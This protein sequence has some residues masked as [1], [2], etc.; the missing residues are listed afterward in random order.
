MHAQTSVP[1][2]QIPFV[3]VILTHGF[4]LF[5][6]FAG[7]SAALTMAMWLPIFAGE[8]GFDSPLPLP[9]W[10]AHEMLFGFAAAG[11]AGFLLA[12]VP[13]WTNLPPL[14]GWRLGALFAVWLAGRIAAW[15]SGLLPPLVF[16]VVDVLFLPSLAAAV[17]PG[18][19]RRSAKRNGVFVLLIAALVAGNV[20]I[21]VQPIL[22]IATAQW[23]LVLAIDVLLV[24]IAVIGGRI[25]PAFTM[26]GMREAGRAL[27]IAPNAMLDWLAIGAIALT[28]LLG[29][30]TAPPWFIGIASGA[31][32]LVNLLRLVRWQGWKTSRVPLVWILHLGYGWLVI[33]LTL[34]AS[35]GFGLVAEAT[36]LHALG[37]GAV[38]T[39]ILAVM[40][41][42]ALGH[43]GR[44][45]VASRWTTLAYLLV[46]AGA[47][48]RVL[49][50][51]FG[52]AQ[53]D[54]LTAAA[55]LWSGGFSVYAIHY[56]PIL[57]RPRVD[58]R[59]G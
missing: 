2:E 59:P 21:H 40:S 58:G 50:D 46:I 34:R 45:L 10:H 38:A 37:A 43:T 51:A 32:A 27:T 13:N 35:A 17:L 16:A 55:L 26:S 1:D 4:R 28:A 41:R 18:I 54:M 24:T 20:A 15:L 29:A 11:M 56:F 5:F 49:A 3:S 52:D 6:L 47:A 48:L 14:Q 22:D 9:F 57:T 8:I 31:A 33:G 39:M 36:A 30:A 42:A 23:G 53:F 12:A 7:I 25:V 44:P 19:L